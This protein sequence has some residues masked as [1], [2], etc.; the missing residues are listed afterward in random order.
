MKPE[1]AIEIIKDHFP[2]RAMKELCEALDIAIEST[3]KQIPTKPINDKC[4]VCYEDVRN[5][6]GD[7]NFKFCPECGQK[8][9]WSGE[10]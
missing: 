7:D 5:W 1:E 4:T 8:I 2:S 3:E 6:T 10:K 9:D